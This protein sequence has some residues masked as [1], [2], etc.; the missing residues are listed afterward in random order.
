[1]AARLKDD[2][3]RFC[4]RFSGQR[5]ASQGREA[6]KLTGTAALAVPTVDQVSWRSSPDPKCGAHA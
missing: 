1:M 6:G 4:Y 3:Y 2:C 5:R